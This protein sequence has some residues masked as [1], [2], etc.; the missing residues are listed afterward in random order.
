VRPTGQGIHRWGDLDR[1]SRRWGL[2]VAA[3]LLLAPVAALAWFLPEWAPTGD[4]AL[5][6]IRALD[7]G[8][9]STPVLGQPSASGIYTEGVRHI[10]H[11]GPLH[12]YLMALPVRVL[13]GAVGMPLV[14]VI[15]T[16]T[17]LAVSAWAVFRQVGRAAGLAAAAVLAAV[18]FTTGAGSLVNP[19]SSSIAGYPLLATAVLMWCVACGDIRLMPAA[20]AAASFTAQQHLSVVPATLVVTLGALALLA[21]TWRR[22]GRWRDRDERRR[23]ARWSG[24]SALVAL[25]LWAPVLAQQV[26]GNDGNLGQMLWFARHGNSDTLG[27]GSAVGQVAHAVGLPPLL[28]RTR[29]DGGWLLSSPSAFGW[30]SA[31]AVVAAVAVAG[32]RWREDHPRRATLCAMAG[33]VAAAG[34][35]NGA[36]VPEGIERYR[37]A[38]YHW[39]FVLALFV[40]LVG[41]LAAGDLLR[42]RVLADRR[43]LAP[44]LAAVTVVA[45][46]A[47]ATA[48]PL[49]D[50]P[51]NTLLA[52]HATTERS[53]VDDIVD[54]VL[55]H[56]GEWGDHPVWL[57]R[58]EPLYGGVTAAFVYELTERGV[59]LR[60]PLYYR[61]YVADRHLVSREAVDSGIVF[62]FDDVTGHRAPQGGELIAEASL[63][64]GLDLEAYREL[65]SAARDA[66]E[67]RVGAAAEQYLA[68]VDAASRGFALQALQAV[69]DDPETALLQRDVLEWVREYPPDEPALDPETAQRL[70][71]SLEVVDVAEL[72]R[73][74][75]SVH[76]Y[77]VDRQELLD[78]VRVRE[79]G[80]D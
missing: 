51:A 61:F 16:G 47:T 11:P 76:V 68:G 12:F 45:M 52:A 58:R 75:R 28:G 42:G 33:V 34:L 71:D 37:L 55:E 69:V 43:A 64:D 72:S 39:T 27:Y 66:D 31:G 63:I 4:P 35:V 78:E 3:A 1:R 2:L 14:S 60:H 54:Q 74:L 65:A 13:G 62:V 20:I 25:V 41:A 67:L 23:L 40:T 36:S 17:C 29:I 26:L 15:I 32:R 57:S 46:A 5:M 21:A 77:L 59:D 38:F 56:R 73:A 44:V 18:A 50:R 19:V 10:N 70:L 48:S 8:T 9:A 30:A 49:L 79:L 22:E 80:R 7:V 6:G 24:L 53:H